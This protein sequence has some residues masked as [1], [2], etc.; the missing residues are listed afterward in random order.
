MSAA[1]SSNNKRRRT[2]PLPVSATVAKLLAQV[3]AEAEA[4]TL[5]A[6]SAKDGIL[7]LQP[8]DASTGRLTDHGDTLL[9]RDA[10][11]AEVRYYQRR[12]LPD[13]WR[14]T[15]LE[16]AWHPSHYVIYMTRVDGS[17]RE[18]E[19]NLGKHVTDDFGDLVEVPV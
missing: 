5:E 7:V 8:L 13:S 11:G 9:F 19:A 14:G 16:R 2:Q 10:H 4:A 15:N 17:G 6:L 3:H 18:W 12:H 1:S